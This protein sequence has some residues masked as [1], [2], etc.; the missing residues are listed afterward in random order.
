MNY[1]IGVEDVMEITKLGKA[2]S[3]EIIKNLN[4][5]MERKGNLIVR[6]RVNKSYLLK[7]LGIEEE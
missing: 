7:R 6:G 5:E 3:Y 2:K 1:L 4:D